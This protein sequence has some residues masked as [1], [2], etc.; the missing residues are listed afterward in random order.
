MPFQMGGFPMPSGFMGVG[1]FT[2]QYKCYPMA[3]FSTN[4]ERDYGGKILLPASALQTLMSMPN[5]EYPMMFKLYNSHLSS[6]KENYRETNAGVLEFTADEQCAILPSWMMKQLNINSGEVLT[7]QYATLPKANFVKVQAQSMDFVEDISDHRALFE[8]HLRDFS[9]IT[10]GDM[11]TVHYLNKEYSVKIMETKPGNKGVSIIDTDVNLDFEQPLGY[12]EHME[13]VRNS[14]GTPKSS[15]KSGKITKKTPVKSR[16]ILENAE[17][18]SP[19]GTPEIREKIAEHLISQAKEDSYNQFV[20]KA[21]RLDGKKKGT[22]SKKNQI[23]ADFSKYIRGVPDFE[24]KVGTLTYIRAVK[25]DVPDSERK[26]D[27]VEF[28]GSG[29][30]LRKDNAK[31]KKTKA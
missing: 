16:R 29:T 26:I 10:T 12:E 21:N 3:A 20:G 1:G 15:S 31:K 8:R 11:I 5:I 28:G 24:W 14:A 9:C 25:P 13:K 18:G 27:F 7:V 23:Q 17:V 6:D 22:S 2:R 4:S 19:L 30:K